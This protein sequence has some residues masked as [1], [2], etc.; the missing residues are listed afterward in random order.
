MRQTN[1]NLTYTPR[2]PRNRQFQKPETNRVNTLI[3]ITSAV[4]FV[5]SF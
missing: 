4:G 2:F 5:A 3:F 1:P